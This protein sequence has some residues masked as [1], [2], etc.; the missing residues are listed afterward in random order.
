MGA[1][2]GTFKC[3]MLLTLVIIFFV[4]VD[5]CAVYCFTRGC[6]IVVVMQQA[7][8]ELQCAYVWFQY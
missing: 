1:L 6:S 3:S 2:S 8:N 7:S 4:T 5:K